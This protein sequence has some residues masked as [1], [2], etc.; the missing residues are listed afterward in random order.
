M[1][2]QFD[3]FG[4]GEAREPEAKAQS[5]ST[6]DVRGIADEIEMVRRLEETGR[7][8]VLRKLEPRA[9]ADAPR[10]GFPLRGA[11]VDTETTGLNARKDEIIEIGIVAFSFD[12]AGNIGDVTGIYS[13]LRQPSAAIP[14][15]I[16]R[17]T[18][19]TDAMVA[20]QTIDVARVKALIEPA[21][22]IIAHNAAFDRRFLER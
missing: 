2:Q 17:L 19:I 6:H 22:L 21:D 12:A 10:P 7:F 14:A 13:G 15:D 18:G 5:P 3:L 20:G 1:K 11:I 8:R 9:I 16:T 4:T